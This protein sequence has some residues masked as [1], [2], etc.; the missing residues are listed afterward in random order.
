MR[1]SKAQGRPKKEEE[2]LEKQVHAETYPAVAAAGSSGDQGRHYTADD[3][4][5]Q[6]CEDSTSGA[7]PGAATDFDRHPSSAACLA[8]T[9][10]CEANGAAAAGIE[11]GLRA[12]VAEDGTE[13]SLP[14]SGLS[15]GGCMERGTAGVRRAWLQHAE[16]W[17]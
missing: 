9:L 10:R 12:A 2:P 13:A 16:K 3:S 7:D 5:M 11:A 15:A 1:V 14:M 4:H 8:C 17:G 6:T